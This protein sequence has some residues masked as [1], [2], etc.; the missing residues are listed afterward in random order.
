[1]CQMM[2]YMNHVTAILSVVI[3]WEFII[4]II[5]AP[6]QWIDSWLK[7]DF[8]KGSGV[9]GPASIECHT[10]FSF[11]LRVFDLNLGPAFL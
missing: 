9:L 5:Q 8:F 3:V 11:T 6:H 4:V 2:A 10:C 7:V 1:M